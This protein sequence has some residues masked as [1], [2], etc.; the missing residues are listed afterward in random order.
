MKEN[1]FQPKIHSKPNYQYEQRIRNFKNAKSRKTY[2]LKMLTDNVLHVVRVNYERGTHRTQE[3]EDPVR[4]EQR[5]ARGVVKDTESRLE[6][7]NSKDRQ[8]EGCH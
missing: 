1:Y 8:G 7:C 3:K 2:P 4:E 6:L 5:E